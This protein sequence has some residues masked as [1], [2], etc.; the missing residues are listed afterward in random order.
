MTTI[1]GMPILAITQR[2]ENERSEM[3]MN[4]IF[5]DQVRRAFPVINAD[6]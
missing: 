5:D 6:Y 2:D 4:G 3:R 1:G